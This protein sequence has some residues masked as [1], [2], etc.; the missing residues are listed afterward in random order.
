M[1]KVFQ[2]IV[3][4]DRGNCMQAV[5]ASIFELPLSDVPN[6]IELDD[7]IRPYKK[8]FKDRGYD[9][10]II[11]N[12]PKDHIKKALKYDGGVNGYFYASV[13]SKTFDGVSHAVVIDSNLTVVHD[14]NPNGLWL[15]CVDTDIESVTITKNFYIERDGTIKTFD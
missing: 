6:F 5:I 3:D 4:K 10:G 14:P 7:W 13:S 8:F 2:T 9:Y 11:S 15:G 1:I 12:M